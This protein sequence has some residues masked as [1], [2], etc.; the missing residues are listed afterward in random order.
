MARYRQLFLVGK[1]GASWRAVFVPLLCGAV[2]SVFGCG[3]HLRGGAELPPSVQTL[4]VQAG[5]PYSELAGDLRRAFQSSGVRLV[6]EP[7]EADAVVRILGENTGRRVVSVSSG[8]KVR[9]YE[10]L[11]TVTF[12]TTDGQ[13]RETIAPQSITQNREYTFD[14]TAVLGTAEEE[15]LLYRDMQQQ[16]VRQILQRVQAGYISAGNR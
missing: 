14:E 1:K 5:N 13:G 4:S 15:A 11:Y 16:A 2:L 7:R 3:F 9:E 8:G 12:N 10:L 6:D